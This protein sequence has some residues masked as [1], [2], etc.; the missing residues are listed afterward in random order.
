MMNRARFQ[1]AR[2]HQ[3]NVYWRQSTRIKRL[4]GFVAAAFVAILA[5]GC[6]GSDVT[7]PTPA[8]WQSSWELFIDEY[9]TC[10]MTPACQYSQFADQVVTW[11]GKF[12]QAATS[13]GLDQVQIDLTPKTLVDANGDPLQN[14][15]P[16][17][18]LKD[19]TLYCDPGQMAT[20][21]NVAV[22]ASVTFRGRTR[23][24]SPIAYASVGSITL[25]VY[26]LTGCELR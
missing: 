15:A 11:Q 1:F 5:T 14:T 25:V 6:G 13:D 4:A 17:Q 21:Q 9:N 19:I 26:Y 18:P 3:F 23:S 10:T 8:T 12:V 7:A 2:P 16:P 22:G 20:W 24:G